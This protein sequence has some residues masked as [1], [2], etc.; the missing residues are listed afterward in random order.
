MPLSLSDDA[1]AVWTVALTAS[2]EQVVSAYAVLSED[3]RER[4]AKFRFP[5]H[6][7]RFILTRASL[8]RILA[9]YLEVDPVRITFE[10]SAYGKP[11]VGTPPT[12]LRFSTSHSADK[13][14]IACTHAVEVGVDIECIRRDLDIDG[15]ARRSF[16]IGEIETLRAIPPDVRHLAFLRCWTCKEAYVKA[17]G[18]GLSLAL[19]QF[20]VSA[21]LASPALVLS[22]RNEEFTL[23][24][25]SL[26]TLGV[27]AIEGYVAAVVVKG[28]GL[29]ASTFAWPPLPGASEHDL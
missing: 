13:A 6:R 29:R 19:D 22:T 27:G 23:D 24:D 15:L 28:A 5:V 16:S 11:S 4:A 18:K 1:A 3:E 10:Y 8:R 12:D 21:A 7:D 26:I 14:L 25:W 17:M 2:S 20:D 9:R